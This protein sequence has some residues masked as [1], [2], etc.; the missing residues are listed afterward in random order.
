MP[1]RRR[2]SSCCC[3]GRGA[4]LTCRA[5][6][7][8]QHRPPRSPPLGSLPQ[9]RARGQP[10][11]SGSP[12]AES[13]GTEIDRWGLRG[14]GRSRQAPGGEVA[15]LR[16]PSPWQSGSS[17]PAPLS[18]QQA[19]AAGPPSAA[20]APEA[21]PRPHRHSRSSCSGSGWK[22]ALPLHPLPPP[23]PPCCC[24]P[25]GDR[26]PRLAAARQRG[27][28]G[29]G[30]R[31]RGGLRR[32]G[33]AGRRM[34]RLRARQ[35]LQCGGVM[36]VGAPR[37][38]RQTEGASPAGRA[39]GRGVTGAAAEGEEGA[40]GRDPHTR[41]AQGAAHRSRSGTCSSNSS[42]TACCRGLQRPPGLADQRAP[43]QVARWLTAQA[44]G[45]A[46]QRLAPRFP[47]GTA[48]GRGGGRCSSRVASASGIRGSGR[49]KATARG[50]VAP[51]SPAA[52][53]TSGGFG[54][55]ERG[56]PQRA[57][58]SEVTKRG[59]GRGRAGVRVLTAA[60]LLL[61]PSRLQG[62]GSAAPRPQGCL[63]ARAASPLA[64]A[65]PS[66]APLTVE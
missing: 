61:T 62:R 31:G 5:Q 9:Y 19:V 42:S 21:P 41:T 11:A 30:R 13:G 65:P 64:L 60:G 63:L 8:P 2:P 16:L 40:G 3:G 27:A 45:R 12:R 1:S 51:H 37:G 20:S 28:G 66:Q 59:S 36:G 18:L 46:G 33:A 34:R 44:Q 52:A 15:P 22:R 35:L 49:Q 26:L 17:R 43:E 47:S 56:W 38:R 6:C 58:A 57:C 14:R 32:A 53:G 50:G 55:A 23:P 10:S 24:C 39:R 25:E 29:R 7:F 54:A 48:E 4:R